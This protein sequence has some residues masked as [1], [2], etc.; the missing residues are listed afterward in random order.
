MSESLNRFD[1]IAPHYDA[2]SRLVFGKAI[3]NSQAW[4]LKRIPP[5]SAVLVLGGGSGAILPL[6]NEV[7]PPCSIWYVEASSVML[8]RAGATVGKNSKGNIV[9]IHGTETAIPEVKFDAIITNFLL[10]LYPDA[11]IRK[12]SDILG[13]RLKNG[14]LWLVSDFIDGGKWWHRMMLWLMYRFF[15]LTCRIKASRLP[16]WEKQVRSTGMTEV[17]FRTFYSGFIKSG[18]YVKQ[19]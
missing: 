14:G 4:A 3:L 17:A 1:W 5:D 2:V 6:L 13:E 11:D 15:V 8:A 12:I 18:I 7:S 10:D 19:V 16:N 9:F